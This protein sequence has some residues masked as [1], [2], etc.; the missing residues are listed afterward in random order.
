MKKFEFDSRRFPK[1]MTFRRWIHEHQVAGRIFAVAGLVLVIPTH[2]IAGAIAQIQDDGFSE[3]Q[4]LFRMAFA[5]WRDRNQK[6]N[7][8]GAA[9]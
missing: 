3:A 6:P 4:V 7:Q 1:R 5:G 2:A 9:T 8:G